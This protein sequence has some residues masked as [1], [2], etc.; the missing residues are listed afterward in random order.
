[1]AEV[2]D[3]N[4]PEKSERKRLQAERTA[5][6]SARARLIKLADKTANRQAPADSPPRDW[7]LQRR[8]DYVDFA[9]RVVVGLRGGATHG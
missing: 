4:R 9:R 7:S 8:L 1:M 2:T 6:K 5:A 3:D